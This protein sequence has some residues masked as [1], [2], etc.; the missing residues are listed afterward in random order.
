[1]KHVSQEEFAAFIGLDRADAKHDVCVQAAGTE[2]REFGSLE[3]SPEA[4][5]VWVQTCVRGS[6]DNPLPCTLSSRKGPL[7]PHCANMISSCSF[8]SIHS[9]WPNTVK[10]L[11]PAAPKTT[12]PMPNSRSRSSSHTATSSPRSP[13]QTPPARQ[14]AVRALAFKWIRILYR[15]SITA[16][17]ISS[18]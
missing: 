9:P 16:S 8:L 10:R 13:P 18:R 4:I 11:S 12:P 14:A 6:T 7:C 3:H 1:M 2:R 15:A 5:D 17:A